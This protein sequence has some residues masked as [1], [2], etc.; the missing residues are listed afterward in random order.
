MQVRFW[1]VRGSCPTPNTTEEFQVRLKNVLLRLG[2][3][4]TPPDLHDAAA[5]DNWLQGLPRFLNTLTG[6]NTSCIEVRTEAGDLL[7]IDAG[8]GIRV[9]GNHLMQEE[10]GRGQGHAHVFF[11]H[12]HW[13]HL[14]GWPFFAPA[15]IPGNRLKCM[16]ATP[17]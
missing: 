1:G 7:I 17:T 5:I 13:D 10:F 4:E 9:L 2:Q 14:Q 12:Y 8:T 15:Y 16:R 6:G 3:E 11:T